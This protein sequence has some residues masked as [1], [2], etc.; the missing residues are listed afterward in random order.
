MPTMDRRQF[1]KLSAAMG[2][3]LAWGGAFENG[4]R[5]PYRLAW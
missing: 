4:V 3:A 5:V 2:A 1:L